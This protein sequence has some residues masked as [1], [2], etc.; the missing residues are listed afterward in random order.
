M[1]CIN[2]VNP[3]FCFLFKFCIL[4]LLMLC[5]SVLLACTY[6][7]HICAWSPQR[8]EDGG[9]IPW[10][11]SYEWLW[12][13]VWVLETDPSPPQE[14]QA[15]L[16]TEPSLQPVFCGFE[17]GFHHVAILPS[18]GIAGMCYHTQCVWCLNQLDKFI[19]NVCLFMVKIFKVPPNFFKYTAY[20]SHLESP[21][22][23]I[24][25]QKVFLLSITFSFLRQSH[26][27]GR[28]VTHYGAQTA[29]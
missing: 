28:P 12:A 9:Q 19:S 11:C 13:A 4:N 24:A 8:S 5:M 20:C 6:V 23:G 2:S 18:A 21:Y 14:Q 10:N 15:L 7:Y 22:R 1:T 26:S 17:A 3:T 29:L 16:N 27:S 25:H